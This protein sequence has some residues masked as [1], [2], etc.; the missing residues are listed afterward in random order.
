MMLASISLSAT[1]VKNA[2]KGYFAS[3]TGTDP[4]VTKECKN[5]DGDAGLTCGTPTTKNKC[6]SPAT[7]VDP[8]T[9]STSCDSCKVED[10]NN[11]GTVPVTYL[12][13]A[14]AGET[15]DVFTYVDTTT[16]TSV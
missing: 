1:D 6:S 4:A 10:P 15:V 2:I 7:G 3:A 5:S 9:I 12:E 14:C 13:I 8:A 16:T 11:A